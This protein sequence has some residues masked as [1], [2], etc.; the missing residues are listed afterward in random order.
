M[1]AWLVYF[2][3]IFIS[4]KD[5]VISADR[6]QHVCQKW[7]HRKNMQADLNLNDFSYI[8]SYVIWFEPFKV[9]QSQKFWKNNLVYLF[10][11]MTNTSVPVNKRYLL[12]IQKCFYHR[13][14]FPPCKMWKPHKFTHI[15]CYR[16]GG[17]WQQTLTAP[18]ITPWLRRRSSFPCVQKWTTMESNLLWSRI[19]IF[20]PAQHFWWDVFY[21]LRVPI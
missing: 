11:Y 19:S 16:I 17:L 2:S 21:H 18:R 15:C 13:F 12:Y 1:S 5:V 20:N 9:S 14:T 3:N 8:H 10:S 7:K 6:W 4:G